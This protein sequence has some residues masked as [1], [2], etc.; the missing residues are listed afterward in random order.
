MIAAALLLAS[1]A[2]ST[3]VAPVE[4]PVIDRYYQCLVDQVMK[5]EKSRERADLVARAATH[6]CRGLF[7]EAARTLRE[8]KPDDA[9]KFALVP[10]DAAGFAERYRAFSVDYALSLVVGMRAN[11]HD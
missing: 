2:A 6:R 9:R 8:D 7:A 10:E 11:R 1:Q 5:L 4:K 3:A